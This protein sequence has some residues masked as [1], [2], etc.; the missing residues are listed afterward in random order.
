MDD[1][2]KDT[3]KLGFLLWETQVDIGRTQYFFDSWTKAGAIRKA[4]N[5]YLEHYN[6][7]Y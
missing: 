1:G 2:V 7:E 5:F 3:K 6:E 4:N